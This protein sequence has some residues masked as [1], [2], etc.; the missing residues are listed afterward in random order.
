M[1]ERKRA[2]ARETAKRYLEKGT[3][4]D[5]FEELYSI[6]K[7]NPSLI[8]WANFHPNPNLF[9]WI[10]DYFTTGVGKKSRKR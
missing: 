3:P 7:K 10:D 2:L 5:W 9:A 6:G 8:P 1:A 4:L